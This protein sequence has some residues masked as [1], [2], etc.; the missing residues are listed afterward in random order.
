MGHCSLSSQGYNG[1]FLAFKNVKGSDGFMWTHFLSNLASLINK[2]IDD[3]AA[4]SSLIGFPS[5]F[6]SLFMFA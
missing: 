1:P 2:K 4:V 3:I 5:H 6:F